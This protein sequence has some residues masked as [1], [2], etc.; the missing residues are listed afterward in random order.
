MQPS[1]EKNCSYLESSGIGEELATDIAPPIGRTSR[2]M[3]WSIVLSSLL[4][5]VMMVAMIAHGGVAVAAAIPGGLFLNQSVGSLYIQGF[6]Q[7]IALSDNSVFTVTRIN[8]LVAN[9]VSAT[10]K[11]DVPG[12]G[13]VVIRAL[14]AKLVI[15]GL[16]TK[17]TAP[18]VAPPS[19]VNIDI[20][21]DSATIEGLSITISR[22]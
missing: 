22:G 15:H 6:A 9:Q 17:L 5:L 7:Q 18:G 11:V 3:Y 20:V 10:V 19:L 2:S 21:F 1:V 14:I 4:A 13:P 8:L 16:Y 12:F